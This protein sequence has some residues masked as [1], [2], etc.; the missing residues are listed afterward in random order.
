MNSDMNSDFSAEDLNLPPEIV[1]KYVSRRFTD[2]E[3]CWSAIKNYDFTKV[4][5]L[6][7]QMKGNGSSFGFPLI[8][9]I[10]GELEVAAKNND[11]EKI[12]DRLEKLQQFLKSVK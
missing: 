1:Q 6:A 5:E 12:T 3:V 9:E 11:A 8:T 2:V 10:G 4:A 7:H